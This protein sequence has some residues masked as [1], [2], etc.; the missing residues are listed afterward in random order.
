LP[1]VFV[2][3][4]VEATRNAR[5]P[6][7]TRTVASYSAVRSRLVAF[8][9]PAASPTVLGGVEAGASVGGDGAVDALGT[10]ADAGGADRL[11][12]FVALGTCVA[13]ESTADDPDVADGGAVAVAEAVVGSAPSSPAPIAITTAATATSAIS[14][15]ARRRRGRGMAA[16]YEDGVDRSTRR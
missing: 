12:R 9:V 10:A 16:S 5:L 7:S 1:D 8:T 11:V 2:I 15:P 14:Q 13:V 6:K 4:I 3:V